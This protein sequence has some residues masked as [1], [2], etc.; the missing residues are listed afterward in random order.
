MPTRL[1]ILFNRTHTF[2]LSN[3]VVLTCDSPP[4]AYRHSNRGCHHHGSNGGQDLLSC[5]WD[6]R[7]EAQAV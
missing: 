2:A 1:T 6:V 3:V 5:R 7:N 4:K